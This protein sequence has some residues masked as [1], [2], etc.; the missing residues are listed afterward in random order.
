M[1]VSVEILT[2]EGVRSGTLEVS[3]RLLDERENQQAVRAVLD[4]YMANQRQGDASTRTRGEVS[5]GGRK[6]WKQK[7]T[8]R[9]RAGSTRSPLWHGGGTSFG[10][11]PRDY[12]YRVNSKVRRLAYRSVL[13]A[14]R[15]AGRLIVVDRIVLQQ[16]KTRNVV[17][18][19]GNLGIGPGEKALILTESVDGDLRRAAANLGSNSDYP[20]GVLPANNINIHDLLCC[21]YLVVTATVLRSLE[22]SWT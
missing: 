14:L 13:S 11:K 21:D 6:P 19:R 7:G 1:S 15:R 20:T 17:V 10:P 5:G 8:G 9:A 3:D 12:G 16:A 22:E 2:V 4:S 18:V